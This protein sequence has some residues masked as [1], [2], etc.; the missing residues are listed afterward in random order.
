MLKTSLKSDKLTLKV[1]LIIF[2]LVLS[3]SFLP[4][5]ALG[6]HKHKVFVDAKASGKQ[7][8]S[9]QNPFKK[10]GDALDKFDGN[11]EVHIKN[12]FY[13]E[14]LDLDNGDELHG[15]SKSGVVIEA[16][17]E[18]KPVI[19]MGNKTKIIK[20]TLRKGSNGVL[21]NAKDK[22]SI[23]ECIIE[24]NDEDGI[25]IKSDGTDKDST[26]TI[27]KNT[28]R[29][30]DKAGIFSGKRKLSI[31]DNEINENGGDGI[32]LERGTRAWIGDNKIKNNDRSGIKLGIDS[33]KI[34]TK[35]NSIRDNGREGLEISFAGKA[36]RITI[37]KT[38]LMENNR[39]GI[40]RVQKG[41]FAGSA[42][43]WNRYLLFNST[44]QFGDNKLGNVA[45]VF[46]VK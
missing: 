7:D 17:N 40:A 14:N 43:L 9:S 37:A 6:G 16:R 19:K 1:G 33:S 15:E 26:V 30:N 36:G 8:G 46:V 21:V 24:R 35:N 4:F 2:F 27:A 45:S 3:C 5:L 29:K 13:L 11:S 42:N 20:L 18:D 12:G 32:D 41:I 23:I 44:N 34:D 31:T 28:V 10:I 25:K 38:K 39:F 22:V